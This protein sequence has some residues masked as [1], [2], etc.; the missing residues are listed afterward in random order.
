MLDFRKYFM[1]DRTMEKLTNV[2]HACVSY[3][4]FSV[5][6][7]IFL[8]INKIRISCTVLYR[9]EPSCLCLCNSKIILYLQGAEVQ[10]HCDDI[11]SRK[12]PFFC[13]SQCVFLKYKMYDILYQEIT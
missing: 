13:I 11:E 6:S 12:L 8:I 7:G 10:S 5:T 2:L 3:I 1:A 9:I 4:A